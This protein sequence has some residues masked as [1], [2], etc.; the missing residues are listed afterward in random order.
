MTSKKEEKKKTVQKNI[1]LYK[2]TKYLILIHNTHM[3]NKCTTR[4]NFSTALIL[5][6]TH[7]YVYNTPKTK[8]ANKK[9]KL[10]A[11]INAEREVI[12]TEIELFNV[13]I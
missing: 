3:C 6:L 2:Q 11:L 13:D 12:N 4:Q 1:Q 8:G 9:L 10:E 7:T 5:T